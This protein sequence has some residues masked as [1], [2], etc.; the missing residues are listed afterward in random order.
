MAH[1]RESR[2]DVKQALTDLGWEVQPDEENDAEILGGHG[3]YHLMV[4]F[5]DG[6]PVSVTIS[7]VG[8]GGGILSMKWSGV[9][10]LPTPRSVVRVLSK[11]V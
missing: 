1:E 10:R 5:E 6:E 3:K 2:E 7:Y 4:S 8:K 9:A 11:D